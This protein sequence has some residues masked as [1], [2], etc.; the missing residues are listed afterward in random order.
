MTPDE[1]E[2]HFW[3]TSVIGHGGVH[4]VLSVFEG[5]QERR[6]VGFRVLDRVAIQCFDVCITVLSSEV[7]SSGYSMR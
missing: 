3:D 1:A 7:A 6:G 2:R 5:R 4:V